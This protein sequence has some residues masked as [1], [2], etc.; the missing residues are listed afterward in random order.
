[1]FRGRIVQRAASTPHHPQCDLVRFNRT[2][3]SML[4]CF[5]QENLD[6]WDEYLE[7]LAFAYNTAVHATTGVSPFQML[8][9]QLPR[10][11]VDLIFPSEISCQ[12]ELEPEDYVKE[13]EIAMKKVLAFV[14]TIREGNIAREKFL[15]DRILPGKKFKLLDRVYLKN[16][17]PRVGVSKKLKLKFEEV[18]TF[19]AILEAWNEN[20]K[21]EMYRIKH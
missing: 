7:P 21:E 6:D 20:D 12:F 16:D 1:M 11:P 9:G 2:L 18:Y 14:A 15:H 17:K 10:L 4:R 19:V 3:E 5:I 13:K 8:F